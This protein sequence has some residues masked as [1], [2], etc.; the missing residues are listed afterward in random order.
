V[1]IPT[2]GKVVRGKDVSQM[3]G[4]A[5]S[6]PLRLSSATRD[7]VTRVLGEPLVESPAGDAV[8]YNWRVQK[9]VAVWPL[10]FHGEGIY[11][12]RTL[13]LRFGADGRLT[14]AHVMK[15]DQPVVNVFGVDPLPPLPTD[16]S[17]EYWRRR[18]LAT[19]RPAPVPTSQ[20]E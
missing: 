18:G 3:V 20:P 10:C 6:K 8:A 1:Y 15:A 19:N 7:D 11:G 16:L 17:Q 13:V 2:F 12:E 4:K 9:G 5:H 14:S